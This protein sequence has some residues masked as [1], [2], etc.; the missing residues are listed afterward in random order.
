[1]SD[2]ATVLA[3]A[4]GRIGYKSGPDPWG[5]KPQELEAAIQGLVDN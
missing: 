2:R 3:Y 1:M 5:F 4:E